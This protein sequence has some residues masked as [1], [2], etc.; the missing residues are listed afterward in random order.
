MTARRA[1]RPCRRRLP[2]GGGWLPVTARWASRPYRRQ[3]PTGEGWGGRGQGDGGSGEFGEKVG[4]QS[5]ERGRRTPRR[6]RRGPRPSGGRG[7]P[8]RAICGS[9]GGTACLSHCAY[10]RHPRPPV[11]TPAK[12][13]APAGLRGTPRSSP[14][15]PQCGFP[16]YASSV[17][18]RHRQEG[19]AEEREEGGRGGARGRGAGRSQYLPSLAEEGRVQLVKT[20]TTPAISATPGRA[21]VGEPEAKR[22]STVSGGQR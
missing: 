9:G 18:R 20:R 14:S 13:D 22:H 3:L 4:E 19:G 6:I 21:R 15:T 17:P 2:I 7:S 11:A 5:T 16:R 12:P 1:S 10:P 8:V